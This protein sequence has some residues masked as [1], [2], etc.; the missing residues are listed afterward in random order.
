MSKGPLYAI[1]A[2]LLVAVVGGGLYLYREETK[3]GIELKANENGVSL[4]AN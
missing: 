4:Q 1:I 3:P 2:I